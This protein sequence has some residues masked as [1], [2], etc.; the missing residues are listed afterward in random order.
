MHVYSILWWPQY[1]VSDSQKISLL[2]INW[3][4]CITSRI[5]FNICISN[6]YVVACSVYVY[7]V[8]HFFGS[9]WFLDGIESVHV[10]HRFVICI[11]LG[12]RHLLAH[13]TQKRRRNITL[14]IQVLA[15]DRQNSVAGFKPVNG[16]PTLPSC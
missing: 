3:P 12:I 1:I 14:E 2:N 8:I 16:I 15:W 13:W 7:V 10:F 5:Q 6:C 4:L 9:V 11:A